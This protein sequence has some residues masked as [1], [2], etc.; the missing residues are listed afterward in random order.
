L[1]AKYSLNS[2]LFGVQK[3]VNGEVSERD[4]NDKKSYPTDFYKTQK[5]RLTWKVNM[6]PHLLTKFLKLSVVMG[7]LRA[8][9]S[10]IA[11]L[12]T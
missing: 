11:F 9:F 12:G 1:P 10:L 3:Y 8:G 4:M 5:E 6:G 7:T 2:I